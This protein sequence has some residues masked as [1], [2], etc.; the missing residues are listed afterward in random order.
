MKGRDLFQDEKQSWDINKNS[1]SPYLAF[2]IKDKPL[3]IL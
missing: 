1:Q 3:Q 2:K